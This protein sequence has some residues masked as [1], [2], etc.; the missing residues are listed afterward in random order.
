MI[1]HVF[2]FDPGPE[3]QFVQRV[4][5]PAVCHEQQRLIRVTGEPF[6]EDADGPRAGLVPLLGVGRQMLD[7]ALLRL[8]PELRLHL[9]DDE[10]FERSERPLLEFVIELNWLAGVLGHDL[11]GPARAD[12]RACD[13]EIERTPR[14]DQCGVARLRQPDF[15]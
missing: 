12:E 10:T 15:I 1:R 5:Q 14:E 13:N 2:G 4:E 9:V 6:A 7:Q 3:C 8:N 11:G